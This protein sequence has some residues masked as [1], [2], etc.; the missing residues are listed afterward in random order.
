VR[1]ACRR[2]LPVEAEQRSE[3]VVAPIEAQPEDRDCESTG[4]EPEVAEDEDKR[5]QQQQRIDEREQQRR[6]VTE[7]VRVR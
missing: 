3:V 1:A 6:D 5:H 2:G 7:R 4:A